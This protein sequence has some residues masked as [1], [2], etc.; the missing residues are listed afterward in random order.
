MAFFEHL[1]PPRISANMTGGPRFKNNKAYSPNGQ[2]VVNRSS[3]YPLWEYACAHP[4]RNGPEFKELRAFF[5]VV[6]GDADGFLFKDWADFTC[7]A[8]ESSTTFVS[9]GV[10]QLNK[11]YTIGA[12]TFVR[13]IY[14]PK[15]GA[16][17][18]RTRSSVTT[19]IT[20]S[21]TLNTTTGRVTV[22]GHASGDVYTWSGEFY[23]PVAFKNPDAIFNVIGGSSMLIE[24]PSIELEEIRL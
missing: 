2:R 15:A 11:V 17:I 4:V 18:F 16:S 22:T 14:K 9:A 6:G 3:I 20:G 5:L 19:D 21:S 7:S 13:P 24:W 12:R 8:S 1:F 10:Y 23:V